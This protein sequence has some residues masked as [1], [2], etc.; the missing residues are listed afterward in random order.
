M[1]PQPLNLVASRHPRVPSVPTLVLDSR[2]LNARTS[3]SRPTASPSQTTS[4]HFLSKPYTMEQSSITTDNHSK[5]IVTSISADAQVGNF[6]EQ[7][8][9]DT[10]AAPEQ[11]RTDIEQLKAAIKEMNAAL[12]KTKVDSAKAADAALEQARTDIKRLE[13]AL[14]QSKVDTEE[15][16]KAAVDKATSKPQNVEPRNLVVCIDGTSNQFGAKVCPLTL[17]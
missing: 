9:T 4:T 1:F 5:A 13:A 11:A 16:I 8:M 12:E 17:F 3:S 2:P 15:K 7:S 6:T 14:E 10:D